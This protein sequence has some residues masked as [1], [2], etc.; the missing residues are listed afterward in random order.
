M[1]LVSD[2][3][4][5]GRHEAL[6]TCGT[7]ANSLSMATFAILITCQPPV[8]PIPHNPRDLCDTMLLT[9]TVLGKE[10]SAGSLA[11]SLFRAV[12]MCC[13]A[14]SHSSSTVHD[15]P[16]HLHLLKF[17]DYKETFVTSTAHTHQPR[18]L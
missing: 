16:G 15:Q 11:Q 3:N 10:K 17:G 5:R 13:H 8:Q 18:A 2:S 9:V 6:N 7:A 4:A 1:A 12:R 14:V